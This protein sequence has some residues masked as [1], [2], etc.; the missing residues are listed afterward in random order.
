MILHIPPLLDNRGGDYEKLRRGEMSILIE[1]IRKI[2]TFVYILIFLLIFNLFFNLNYKWDGISFIVRSYLFVFSFYLIFNCADIKINSLKESY[3]ERFGKK[4]ELLLFLE[5]RVLPFLFIYL[6]TIIFTLIDYIQVSHWPDKPLLALLDGRYSNTL[7][8][9]LFLLL[10]LKIKRGPNITIP[11]FLIV[12]V[13]YFFIDK[14]MYS[15][16]GSGLIISLFKI[17]KFILFIFFLLY[18]FFYYSWKRLVLIV[19]SSIGLGFVLYFLIFSIFVGVFRHSRGTSYHKQRAGM[20]LLKLGFSFPLNEL[21]DSVLETY[22]VRLFKKL[23]KY[24]IRYDLSLEYDDHEWEKLLFSRSLKM[25]D[26]ISGYILYKN[27]DLSYE[28]IIDYAERESLRANTELPEASNFI[29]IASRY[30]GDHQTD[31]VARIKRQNKTFKLWGM[32]VLGEQKKIESIPLLLEYLTDIDSNI[33]EGAYLALRNI[34]GLDPKEEMDKRIID[35]QVYI[36]FRDF[37]IQNHKAR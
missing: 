20:L 36:I 29:K 21:K 3:I 19:L 10:I 22:D 33:S 25:T 7:I 16:S 30:I 1:Q 24:S 2:S 34:T 9:S 8:Y 5:A 35:P 27:I 28:R 32:A 12:S 4:G 11:L 26:M 17:S 18:E 15:F 31:F 14:F 13:L 6:I 23:L 37:Y